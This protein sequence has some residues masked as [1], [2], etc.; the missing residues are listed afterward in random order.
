MVI[1]SV[2]RAKPARAAA[3]AGGTIV[4]QLVVGGDGQNEKS[5]RAKVVCPAQLVATVFLWR[6]LGSCVCTFVCSLCERE[7]ERVSACA[8]CGAS[9]PPTSLHALEANTYR[10]VASPRVGAGT[11]NFFYYKQHSDKA[12]PLR[13]ARVSTILLASP[14]HRKPRHETFLALLTSF[15]SHPPPSQILRHHP[16]GLRPAPSRPLPAVSQIERFSRP[17]PPAVVR[18]VATLLCLPLC[19]PGGLEGLRRPG[20]QAEPAEPA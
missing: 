8:V 17:L 10:F 14:R 4:P 18:V 1:S 11:S 2:P 12:Q 13:P 20:A 9:Q 19:L 5:E 3:W 6:V 7:S 15:S 16:V